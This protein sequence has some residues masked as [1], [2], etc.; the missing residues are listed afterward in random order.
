[1]RT[2]LIQIETSQ[3]YAHTN[4]I[5]NFIPGEGA[6]QS[7]D[8]GILFAHKDINLDKFHYLIFYQPIIPSSP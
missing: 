6:K 7:R 8:N 3:I 5:M 2:S 4:S 1:M